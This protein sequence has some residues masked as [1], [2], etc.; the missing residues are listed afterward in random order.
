[1]KTTERLS[2]DPLKIQVTMELVDSDLSH[3]YYEEDAANP[4]V[5]SLMMAKQKSPGVMPQRIKVIV[6]EW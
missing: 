4:T 1:M 2:P 5:G 3:W 6:E